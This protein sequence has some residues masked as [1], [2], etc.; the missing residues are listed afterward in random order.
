MKSWLRGRVTAFIGFLAVF[1]LVTGGLGWVTAAVLRLEQEQ[2][3]ARDKERHLDELRPALWQLDSNIAP[4]LAREDSRPWHHY[5]AVYPPPVLF[6]NDKTPIERGTV[7]EPSPL[8]SEEFPEW[9]QLHFW[10]DATH[11]WDSPQILS[12]DLTKILS[13]PKVKAPLDNVTEE[14][15]ELRRVLAGCWTSAELLSCVKQKTE[16]ERL[17]D[18]VVL[19]QTVAANNAPQQLLNM[20]DDQAKNFQYIQPQGQQGQNPGKFNREN[21][22]NQR[23]NI[24][25]VQKEMYQKKDEGKE[26]QES[27]ALAYHLQNGAAWF[28]SNKPLKLTGKDKTP[29]HVGR[30][31]KL[32]LTPKDQE[33]RLLAARLVQIG[34][35]EICQGIVL[36]WPKLQAVLHDLVKDD[37]PLAQFKPQRGPIPQH[38]ERTMTALPVEMDP[39]PSVRSEVEAWTPLRIGL[40]LAW[41]AALVALSAVGLG[42]WSLIDLSERRIRFVSAVTHELRTPLTT[43]RLYL[44][45]LAGGL[46]KEE[47]QQTQYLQ[48]LHAETDRLHRLVG[49]VLDFS[50]LEN[51]RPRLE[52]TKVPVAELLEQV[53]SNWQGRCQSAEKELIVENQVKAEATIQT[54]V[55]IAQQILA[56][57][58][59]NAC[60]YSKDAFDKRIW[61]RAKS[62]ADRLVLEVEDRGPGVPVRERR[63]IFRPFRRGCGADVTA[64]GVGLGLALARQWSRLLGGR[65][66]LGSA[67]GGTGACFRVELPA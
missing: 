40:A 14:R 24:G 23:A 39:G 28:N 13:N 33:E 52:K 47:A 30:M 42:G 21:D 3:D 31:V 60:K 10:A 5:M 64:G 38:P 66:T 7:L 34:D 8:Q 51:Q 41:A 35:Q 15:C 48:T 59:D 50:R 29:V 58:I 18:R 9:M 36:D 19:E 37:F 67:C 11:G 26:Q 53:R 1:A 62:E 46:V 65:L 44:D 20:P 55:N 57:L 27:M 25:N 12:Q 45:M 6:R 43:L 61:L 49:N 22:F 32:W 17:N 54:D 4:I 63:S 2:I 56:N 16:Q